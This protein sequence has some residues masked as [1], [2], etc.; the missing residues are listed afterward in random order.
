MRTLHIAEFDNRHRSLSR[1]L[2]RSAHA[3]F[4]RGPGIVKWLRPEGQDLSRNCMLA[5]G[6]NQQPIRIRALRVR[7][8]HRNLRQSRHL[9]RTNLVHLPRDGGIIAKH[10]EQKRVDR[11]FAGQNRRA[12][13]CARRRRRLGC[14]FFGVSG[15]LSGVSLGGE[16][17]RGALAGWR[18]AGGGGGRR[19]WGWVVGVVVGGGGGGGVGW[20]GGVGGT[21]QA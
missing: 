16:G 2:R 10:L 13:G 20:G 8:H 5:V 18:A 11:V 21:Q 15:R 3:F 6:A 17:G 1:S 12:R 9:G 4:Q 14:R 19:A 7:D